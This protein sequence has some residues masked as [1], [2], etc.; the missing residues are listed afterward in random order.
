MA[1]RLVF[2]IFYFLLAV[3]S[4]ALSIHQKRAR[5]DFRLLQV[6]GLVSLVLAAAKMWL[7]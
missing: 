5:K 1:Y 4:F 7:N 6:L 2:G 3:C